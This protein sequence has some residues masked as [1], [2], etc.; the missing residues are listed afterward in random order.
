MKMELEKKR[1]GKDCVGGLTKRT[2]IRV[3]VVPTKGD[4][5]R[6]SAKL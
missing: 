1:E 2:N 4:D 5:G 6:E 3:M